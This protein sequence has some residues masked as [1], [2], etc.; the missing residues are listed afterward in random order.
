[1]TVDLAKTANKTALTAAVAS[2]VLEEQVS[3]VAAV[4]A[5]AIFA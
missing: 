4:I 3:S 5:A 2:G 1:M